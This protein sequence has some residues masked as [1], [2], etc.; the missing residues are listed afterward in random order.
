MSEEVKNWATG[1][2][3]ILT[4]FRDI[5]TNNGVTAFESKGKQFDPHIHEAVEMVESEDL[6]DGM[7]VEEFNKGYKMG[8]KVIRPA[9]VC[10]S[11]NRPDCG[12]ST[13][14]EKLN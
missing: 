10:V 4:Q 6:A 3:M 12:D 5:L 11:K 13:E 1:F 9:R 14:T 2:Q 7:V 8:D